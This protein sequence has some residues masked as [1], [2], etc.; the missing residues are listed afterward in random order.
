[1]KALVLVDHGSKVEEANK[2]LEKICTSLRSRPKTGFD[3][4]EY[5]H[6]EL[7]EPTIK[8]AIDNCVSKGADE[9][10]VH[11]YFLSPG[12][13]SKSDIPRMVKKATRNHDGL[14]YRV[15]EPLGFHHKILEVI[16]ERAI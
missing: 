12:R 6:M 2:L 11:P 10:V 5:C 4:I 13:H 3:I 15:T 1:M 16:I 8:Q 9:I 14:I 7:A